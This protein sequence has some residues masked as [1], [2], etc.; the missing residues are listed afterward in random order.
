MP[1]IAE[2]GSSRKLIDKMEKSFGKGKGFKHGYLRLILWGLERF[3]N[4]NAAG[5]MTANVLN[6]EPMK[7]RSS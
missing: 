4:P 1:D 2:T 6:S 5:K 3:L 7:T